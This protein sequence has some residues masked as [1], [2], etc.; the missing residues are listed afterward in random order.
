MRPFKALQEL[1]AEFGVSINLSSATARSVFE[2]FKKRSTP[3]AHQIGSLFT[4]SLFF[5]ACFWPVSIPVAY[6]NFALNPL[7]A[8]ETMPDPVKND[9]CASTYDLQVYMLYWA[10]CVDYGYGFDDVHKLQPL[11]PLAM[12]FLANADRELRAAVAQVITPKPNYKGSLAARMATEIF[13]KAFLIAKLNFTEREVKE[14]RHDIPRIA[15]TCHEIM[16]LEAFETIIDLAHLFPL[17]DSRYTGGEQKPSEVWN[18]ISL[19]QVGAAAVIREFSD[20]DIRSPL[21]AACCGETLPFL[22]TKSPA[23][24]PI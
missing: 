2:W 9:L 13:L 10:D 1:S 23:S 16:P 19:C 18:S 11:S 15:K 12:S 3:E 21:I 14:F 20:R 24:P 6:G 4:G 5:D 17:V 22:Q 7:E 8:L